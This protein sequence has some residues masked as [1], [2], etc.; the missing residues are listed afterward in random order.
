[1]N[2]KDIKNKLFDFLKSGD[3]KISLDEAIHFVI[4]FLDSQGIEFTND[5]I[6]KI[7]SEYTR[8]FTTEG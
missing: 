3:Y 7:V 8:Q 6:E 1:M 4:R 2:K 5:E